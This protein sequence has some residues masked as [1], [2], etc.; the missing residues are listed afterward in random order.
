MKCIDA[1]MATARERAKIAADE[2]LNKKKNASPIASR[3]A[4]PP[5]AT[6]ASALRSSTLS[7]RPTG[8]TLNKPPTRPLPGRVSSNRRKSV[9]AR[10]DFCVAA[11][12]AAFP[13]GCLGCSAQSQYRFETSLLRNCNQPRISAGFALLSASVNFPLPLALPSIKT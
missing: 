13:N 10:T 5:K 7:S 2:A 1:V 9:C 6:G 11:W 3:T 8:S 12:I 4:A